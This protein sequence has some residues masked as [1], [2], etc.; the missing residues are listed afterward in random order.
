[1]EIT[2]DE[3]ENSSDENAQATKAE[4]E[5]SMEKYLL[6]N[7]GLLDQIVKKSQNSKAKGSIKGGATRKWPRS[8]SRSKTQI[9]GGV[10]EQTRAE[11]HQL[12]VRKF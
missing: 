1:M 6:S 2:D 5:H 3:S 7:K 10:L 8:R 4:L 11:R 9:L 12:R